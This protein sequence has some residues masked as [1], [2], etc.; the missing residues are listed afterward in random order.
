MGEL[1]K[2]KKNLH[3]SFHKIKE[4][5]DVHLDS[6]NQ[7]TSEIISTIEAL[8]ELDQKIGKLSERMDAIEI[9][10]SPGDRFENEPIT[11][12]IREQEIFLALYSAEKP[13][14]ATDIC[15]ELGLAEDAITSYLYSLVKYGIPVIRLPSSEGIRYALDEQFKQLQAHKHIVAIDQKIAKEILNK[16]ARKNN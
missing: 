7:N 5:L 13:L 3:A 6:I 14:L 11:L 12:S 4:E 16:D 10:L 15:L 1:D 8:N 9:L 2:V